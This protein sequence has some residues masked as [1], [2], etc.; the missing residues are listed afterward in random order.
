MIRGLICPH[1]SHQDEKLRDSLELLLVSDQD[2]LIQLVHEIAQPLGL[3]VEYCTSAPTLDENGGLDSRSRSGFYSAQ[4]AMVILHS[5]DSFLDHDRIKQSILDGARCPTTVPVL[6]IT[7]HCEPEE[8]IEYLRLG[9]ADCVSSPIEQERLYFL[10]DS[11]TVERRLAWQRSHQTV[12]DGTWVSMNGS[13]PVCASSQKLAAVIKQ[14]QKVAPQNTNILMTGETGAGKTR[15][16]R[17]IHEISPR[18]DQPFVVVNCAAMPT[19]LLES[20]LFGH[21]KGA[22]TGADSHQEGKFSYVKGGTLLLDEVDTLSLEAQAKLLRT[23]ESRVFEPIG[24]NE[25]KKFRGRL[26]VATNQDLGKLVQAGTFR[27]DLYYRLNVVDLN[28][29]PLRERPEEIIQIAEACVK[30]FASV[31]K[32]SRKTLSPEVKEVLL[33]YPWPGNIRELRNAVE[34]AMTFATGES[35]RLGDLPKTVLGIQRVDSAHHEQ[36]LPK[37]IPV[38]SAAAVPVE[39]K[40]SVRDFDRSFAIPTDVRS[41]PIVP[42]SKPSQSVIEKS[43]KAQPESEMMSRASSLRSARA[44]GEKQILTEV[45]KLCKNNRSEAAKTLGISRTALYK[46]LAKYGLV[47][48]AAT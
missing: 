34:Q 10:I 1:K 18:R 25:S 23:V 44:I 21:R 36:M 47:E 48:G 20:E 22:F 24:S 42:D 37:S 41:V 32:L 19:Q 31:N 12:G 5:A 38:V 6:V 35:I 28:V 3:N 15:L 11:L 7:D 33:N 40:E 17:M 30:E 26:I 2:W 16:S 43:S 46:K 27:S 45:L 9:A 13:E 14:I 8:M 4:T 39:S 29:P